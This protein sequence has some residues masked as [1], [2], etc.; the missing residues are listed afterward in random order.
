MTENY[1][2][3]H[4]NFSISELEYEKRL[5]ALY[6]IDGLVKRKLHKLARNLSVLEQSP[7]IAYTD[8]ITIVQR[9]SH[10]HALSEVVTE[11]SEQN[12]LD[13][14]IPLDDPEVRLTEPPELPLPERESPITLAEI[15][16]ADKVGIQ[17][18]TADFLSL[19]VP[20]SITD[21][22]HRSVYFSAWRRDFFEKHFGSLSQNTYG[23]ASTSLSTLVPN[24]DIEYH[25]RYGDNYPRRTIYINDENALY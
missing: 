21:R 5:M 10:L 18:A 6:E 12:T 25:Y 1:F 15:E 20:E 22:D 2:P 19:L 9:R 4:N 8:A 23:D 3:E 24:V 14:R 17:Q 11:A 16:Q 7:I 13:V